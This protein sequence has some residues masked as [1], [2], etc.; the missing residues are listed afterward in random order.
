MTNNTEF[1][2][3]FILYDIAPVRVHLF[4]WLRASASRETTHSLSPSFKCH[5]VVV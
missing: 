5:A 2:Y 3:Y 4:L 1:T